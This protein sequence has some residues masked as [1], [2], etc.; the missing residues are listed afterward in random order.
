MTR[1]GVFEQQRTFVICA[2]RKY[3]LHSLVS[4]LNFASD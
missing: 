4:I 3:H 1:K 2:S